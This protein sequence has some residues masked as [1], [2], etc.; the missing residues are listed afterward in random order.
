M[1]KVRALNEE[2]EGSAKTVFRPQEFRADKSC[3]VVSNEGD[4]ELIIHVPFTA[5]AKIKSVCIAGDGDAQHP[6]EVR[7]FT[8]RDD[9]D[10]E[11]GHEL[12]ATQVLALNVDVAGEID[13]PLRTSKFSSVHT[14]TMFFTRSVGGEDTECKIHYIGFKGENM[15]WKRGIVDAVY[16]VRPTAK[17]LED[18]ATA[19]ASVGKA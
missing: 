14:L 1:E 11:N 15:K 5:A 19:A 12:K 16:E 7:L 2:E 4:P 17:A 3:R 9:I 6:V 10:F 18:P 13:Y 8:N